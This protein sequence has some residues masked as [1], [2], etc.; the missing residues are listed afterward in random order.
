M[1]SLTLEEL[2]EKYKIPVNDEQKKQIKS[3]LTAMGNNNLSYIKKQRIYLDENKFNDLFTICSE[4]K[5]IFDYKYNTRNDLEQFFDMLISNN[6]FIKFYAVFCPGYTDTGYKDR[7]GHTTTCKI[8]KLKNLKK[9]CVK[10]KIKCNINCIY[11]DIFLENY[12]DILNP[13]WEQE[14]ELN[15]KLFF[16]YALKYFDEE[17][18][19]FLSDIYSD[20]IYIKGF[21]AE[22]ILTGKGYDDFIKYNKSFYEKMGWSDEQ[23]KY[24]NDKLYT[25]YN[26]IAD[27]IKEKN[28]AV[29]LPMENMYART[30]VFTKKGVCS[31][32]FNL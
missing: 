13:N 5:T 23:I 16:E 17:E 26:I 7:L 22:G 31:M 18:I 12:D 21:I 30:K 14:L 28:N 27:Y 1:T 10:N 2:F 9:F 29:Y 15:K 4:L 8:E 19:T 24:R 3:L 11:A 32:Y 6:D 20:A 25:I